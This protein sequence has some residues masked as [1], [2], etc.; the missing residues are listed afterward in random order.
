MQSNRL[1]EQLETERLIIRT[2]K[3]G[4]GALLNAALRASVAELAPW[5]PWVSPEPSLEAS[6]TTCRKAYGRWLLNE[7]LMA[8]LFLKNS[9]QLIGS[10]GLHKPNWDLRQFEIGYWRCTGYAGQGLITEAVQALAEH[11]LNVLQSSRVEITMDER[12]SASWRVAERAGFEL[13]GTLRNERLDNHGKLR[14]TR[15]YSRVSP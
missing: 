15:V 3:P 11:A 4:D 9:G 6:E 12:N 5:L 13:E 10:S 7:D 8:L 1:P 2:A 14:N